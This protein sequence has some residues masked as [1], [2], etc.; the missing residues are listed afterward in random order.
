MKKCKSI[1]KSVDF[2]YDIQGKCDGG[3]IAFYQPLVE[4]ERNTEFL[5]RL[6]DKFLILLTYDFLIVHI[7]TNVNY[8]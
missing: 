6:T 8:M 1:I 2:F 3:K 5:N 4:K 7:L